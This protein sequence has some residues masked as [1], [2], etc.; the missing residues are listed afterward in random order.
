MYRIFNFVALRQLSK[1]TFEKDAK[2][3]GTVIC[4]GLYAGT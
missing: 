4:A 3:L 2:E 1:T